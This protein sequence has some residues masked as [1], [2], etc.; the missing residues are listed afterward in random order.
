MFRKYLR[1]NDTTIIGNYK[2]MANNSKAGS[3]EECMLWC[4]EIDDCVAFTYCECPE[5][6]GI[7]TC[8]CFQKTL[9]CKIYN[10]DGISMM[11]AEQ[12]THT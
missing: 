5:G 4:Y 1:L 10:S 6:E 8:R 11:T 7:K 12:F 9:N 3:M 2:Q